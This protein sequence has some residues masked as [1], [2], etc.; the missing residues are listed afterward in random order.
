MIASLLRR[1]AGAALGLT[2]ATNGI[3]VEKGLTMQTRDGVTLVAD[4]YFPADG[5]PRPTVL[6]RTPYG[7]GIIMAFSASLLAERGLNVVVQSVR[8]T[9]GSG[10]DFN[11]IRQEGPDGLDTV[12]WV[13]AQPWFGG[14]LFLFGGSYL[15]CTAWA[16]ATMAPDK[17]DGAALT[18]TL[19]N[20]RDEMIEF[21]GLTQESMLTWTKQMQAL[22][23][24]GKSPF[25]GGKPVLRGEHMHL[26]LG[27][28]DHAVTGATVPW[29]Q[30][31]VNRRDPN[32][33]WWDAMDFSEGVTAL[34]APVFLCAGWQDLFLPYELK[35]FMARQ[36]AGLETFITIGP[37]EH[38]GPG[39][40]FEGQRQCVEFLTGL[41]AGEDARARRAPV[42]LF[43]QGAKEWREYPSWPPPHVK[44]GKLYLRAGGRLDL[45]AP[46]LDD[47]P[48]CF[49]YDPADPTPSLYG[50]V[51]M[52][53]KSRDMDALRRRKDVE[54]FTTDRLDSDL[55]IIGP[56]SVELCVRSDRDHSDFYVCLCDV[57]AKG[58]SMH[59][60]DGYVRLE[61]GSPVPEGD[62]VRRIT[63]E[64]W[65][66]AYRFVRG[67]RLRLLVASGAFPRYARNPG[68]GEPMATATEL[69]TA[70]QEILHDTA[71]SSAICFL[72]S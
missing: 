72:Q 18:M 19:S 67:N 45:A 65:P 6:M 4:R 59:V 16:I 63:I 9:T 41:A 44:P 8:A 56:V 23:S 1:A 69:V 47:D 2:K 5:I 62:G 71:R 36:A 39:G 52:P 58:R 37:W 15:G 64:V 54:E 3:R 34:S 33:P 29:W 43:V 40:L 46:T 12:D 21:G 26:P 22:V 66:T 31:W 10:G 17:V 24:T 68:T 51:T 48:T 27:T 32:D 50:P 7:R 60:A 14:K 35:D 55:E 49:V 28:I 13:R 38:G 30:E 42:R 70:R 61:P 20:F 25:F 57:D 53:A 11:P